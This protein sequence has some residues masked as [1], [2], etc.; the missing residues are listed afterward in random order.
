MCT[1]TVILPHYYPDDEH[2]QYI[3]PLATPIL[4]KQT[5]CF[6]SNEEL[7]W[8][9]NGL[10]YLFSCQ[11][12]QLT[13]SAVSDFNP[14]IGL[15]PQPL[16]LALK[17]VAM[18]DVVKLVVKH[19]KYRVQA[20][21]GNLLRKELRRKLNTSF[22]CNRYAVRN[23]F[24]PLP[25]KLV[26]EQYR[27]LIAA[28]EQAIIKPARLLLVA[29]E[30]GDGSRRSL[31]L[32][33][34]N[35]ASFKCTLSETKLRVTHA[36]QPGNFSIHD[37]RNHDINI[38]LHCLDRFATRVLGRDLHSIN[39]LVIQGELLK[40]I[41]NRAVSHACLMG[42]MA[43]VNVSGFIFIGAISRGKLTLVTTYRETPVK[44]EDF[45]R[46]ILGVLEM[47]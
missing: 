20:N 40:F 25:Q 11:P 31:L 41:K 38:T 29:P 8:H 5:D 43:F 6:L 33:D 4:P 21:T 44:T 34:G 1:V 18:D 32:I 30:T 14:L 28:A 47:A 42:K 24:G 2:S 12:R 37:F 45:H 7:V 39:P 36:A 22:F 35:D 26:P 19:R 9:N 16:D 13:L 3:R 23:Y 17:E 15:H 10:Y 27:Q 46:Q